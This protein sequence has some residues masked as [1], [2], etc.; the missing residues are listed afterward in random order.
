[1]ALASSSMEDILKPYYSVPRLAQVPV[2]IAL[3]SC[4]DGAAPSTRLAAILERLSLQ[5]PLK[6]IWKWYS[7]CSMLVQIRGM[8]R[9]HPLP[10]P[11]QAQHPFLI[12]KL[13]RIIPLLRINYDTCMIAP[14]APIN[15]PTVLIMAPRALAIPCAGDTPCSP[16]RC[17]PGSDGSARCTPGRCS[18]GRCTPDRYAPGSNG[19]VRDGSGRYTP[20]RC[21]PGKCAPGSGG[22]AR[23]VPGRCSPEQMHTWQMQPWQSL[24]EKASYPEALAPKL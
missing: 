8:T 4:F 10:T 24:D 2:S 14:G 22:S 18:P 9:D 16:G 3:T 20:G 1:M 5:L 6:A 23:C 19:S 11:C 17:T 13:W 15:A 12:W 21:S 7:Y